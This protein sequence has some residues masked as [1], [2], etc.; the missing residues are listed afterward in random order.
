LIRSRCPQGRLIRSAGLLGKLIFVPAADVPA[1]LA[2]LELPLL[3]RN[4]PLEGPWQEAAQ[5]VLD[6]EGITTKDLRIPHIQRPYF[7][8][9]R[10]R[11]FVDAEGFVLGQAGREG[12]RLRRRISFRLPRGAYATV[13]LRALGQPA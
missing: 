4:S 13:L 6:R 9:G 12:D 1:E 2:G 5:Q 11:L 3:G 7:G 8:K 10:R